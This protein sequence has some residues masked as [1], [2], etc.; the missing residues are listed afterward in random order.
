MHTDNVTSDTL[1]LMYGLP[2][3]SVLGPIPFSMYTLPT[4]DIIRKYGLNYHCYADDTQIYLLVEPKQSEVNDA[5]QQI[6]SCLDKLRQWMTHN[7]LKLN[8]GKTEFI[9]VGSKQKRSKVNITQI[10]LGDTMVTPSDNV[11]N[12]GVI[13]DENLSMDKYITAAC[14]SIQNLGLNRKHINQ[15]VVELLTLASITSRLDMGNSLL[16]GLNK[17]QVHR[18]ER[19][20]NT[21]AWLI[22]LTRKFTHVTPIVKQLHWLPIERDCLQNPT[23][24]CNLAKAKPYV[25]ACENLRS[26]DKL[27]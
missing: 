13:F 6:E 14:L 25:P 22:T 3:G 12:L 8:E 1:Q 11:R 18:L 15:P 7:F 21:A 26:A 27:L 2:Q 10:R 19:L 23:Y 5:I 4:A 24:L 9:V 16:H 20:Q 17:S